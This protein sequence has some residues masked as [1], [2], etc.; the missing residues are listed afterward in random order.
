[1][2]STLLLLTPAAASADVR[3]GSGPDP[4]DSIPSLSGPRAPDV[5]SV[6]ATYD[7]NGTFS[8][9]VTLYEPWS[10][11]TQTYHRFLATISGITGPTP[12]AA[13]SCGDY[14]TSIDVRG[15]LRPS[16]DAGFFGLGGYTGSLPLTRAVSGD[17]R[18]ITFS[19]STPLAAGMDLGCVYGISLYA[20]DPYGHCV[21]S[22]YDCQS[23]SYS[24][25]TDYVPEFLF[26]GRALQTTQCS[27]GVDNDRD[28]RIDTLDYNCAGYDSPSEFG[29]GPGDFIPRPPEDLP[30]PS[31]ERPAS[32]KTAC[33]DGK[34]NDGDG[35]TDRKDPG[36]LDIP[37]GS[38][39]V[40]PRPVRSRSSI[41]ARASNRSCSLEVRAAVSPELLPKRLFPL[42][43]ATLSVKGL[44]GF[45]KGFAAT[46]KLRLASSSKRTLKWLAP[47]R[48][49]VSLSYAGD[50]W[51]RAS[52]ATSR[53]IR[54]C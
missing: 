36:C 17:G 6:Q 11:T 8:V 21:P 41:Q 32:P 51:R 26:A 3:T 15:D 49:R 7:T 29:P 34:D 23:V 19:G 40:D 47:G 43:R 25:G 14:K 10:Q 9:A 28:G 33:S 12:T 20:P 45:A 50:P 5:Q 44:G 4:Q 37:L 18:T 46:R 39:E 54:V 16:S 52:K 42:G 1:V 24:Y 31:Y 27:D 38:S 13:S 2:L 48:Y 35:K 22:N 53:T 30:T